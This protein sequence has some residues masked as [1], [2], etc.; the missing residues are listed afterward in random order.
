MKMRLAVLLFL[1]VTLAKA[2]ATG[3]LKLEKTIPLPEVQGRI[4]HLSV[5]VKGQ[6][7][8]VS[9]LGNNTVEVIDLKAGRRTNTISG[10]QEPQGV[11]YV[12]TADRLYVANAKDGTVKV[13]DGTSLQLLKTIEYGDDADNLRYD[14][15]RQRVYV[16]YG[17]GALGEL[18]TEGQKVTEI[19]LDAHPESFQL[20]KNSPRIYV[21]LP[22]SRKIAVVDRGTHT[23]VTTWSTG[24]SL[25]NYPM[26]LD[27][28]DH[29]LFVVTRIPAR[30]LVIDTVSGK[31][32]Q[33]LS[34]VGD[35]DDVFF[36]QARKRIYAT[37]GDG[38][39]SV[40]E[41]QDVD[42]YKDVSRIP[43]V[44][45]ARTGFFSPELGRLYLAVRRQ[46]S[47]PAA[48]QVFEAGQ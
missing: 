16:G 43:T 17:G 4:D 34:A 20:E 9:A 44:K 29:R 25:A 48:I 2:Q 31:T 40:F 26:A 45:G 18:D 47:A 36:D 41:Q 39:I 21:N 13:F 19:K 12:A 33:K 3:P 35:C 6:R 24:L 1:S 11:L 37:G 7:L 14:S 42:H 30:L 5:D 28:T 10:L 23:V 32:V 46:D 22:K 27:E 38:A 15:S 8:F